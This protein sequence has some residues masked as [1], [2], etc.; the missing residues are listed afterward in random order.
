MTRF[1][2]DYEPEHT[3]SPTDEALEHLKL[4][5][6]KPFYD[7][8]DTRPIPE[9]HEI[10]GAVSDIF[11]AL[12]STLADTQLEPDLGDLLWSTVNV[13]HRAIDRVQRKLDDNEDAQKRSQREQDGSEIRSVEIERLLVE[14]ETLLSR[15][16]TLEAFRDAAAERHEQITGSVWRPQSGSLVN[17]RMM[18]ASIIDSRDFLNARRRAE[19]EVLLPKGALI[20]FTGGPDCNDHDRIWSVLD[21][22]HAKHTNM[23]LLHGGTPTGAERIA[24]CWAD[25]RHVPQVP[26]RPDW[27]RHAKAAP[28]KRND[29]ML[30]AMPIGIVAFPGS[31]ITGN[32]C[33]KARK[34]GIPV[35]R[36]GEG[37]A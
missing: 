1:D 9:P 19:T 16:D 7:E 25:A 31:G 22:I 27:N 23:V 36:F 14:G 2:D 29:R 15:R 4:F 28:F 5:G 20:A 26:F 12:A 21:R 3:A 11:D 6:H 37:G 13:F 30:D 33:D 8:P 24:A 18:T 32:L 17:R 35:W 10:A 34:A